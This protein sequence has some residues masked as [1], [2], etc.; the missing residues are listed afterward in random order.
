MGEPRRFAHPV[1]HQWQHPLGDIV[2]AI[3]RAGLRVEFLHECP[4]ASHAVV[5]GMYEGAGGYWRLPDNRW[6][7]LFSLKASRPNAA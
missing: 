3:T 4:E 7:M 1:T 5:E 6:P 2:S